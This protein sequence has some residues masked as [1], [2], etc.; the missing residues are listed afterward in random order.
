MTNVKCFKEY[1]Y[2]GTL[3][4]L[5]QTGHLVNTEISTDLYV[6]TLICKNALTLQLQFIIVCWF[7]SL[8]QPYIVAHLVLY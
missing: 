6:C 7:D 2:L 4:C 3:Y 5:H 8:C 1:H